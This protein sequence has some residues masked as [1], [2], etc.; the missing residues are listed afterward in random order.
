MKRI[1][2]LTISLLLGLLGA[3]CSSNNSSEIISDLSSIV[4]DKV[5]SVSIKSAGDVVSIYSDET[6][7]FT[8]TV[9]VTGNLSKEVRWSVDD[10]E[11]ATI[12]SNGLLTA[13]KE[14]NVLV[15][16]KS[17]ADTKKFTTFDLTI[18]SLIV[19]THADNTDTLIGDALQFYASNKG[20]PVTENIVWSTSDSTASSI[21]KDGVL[22]SHTWATVTVYAQVGDTKGSFVYTP[23]QK[24]SREMV[25]D[26]LDHTYG[27]VL[28]FFSASS[29]SYGY[30]EEDNAYEIAAYLTTYQKISVV[31]QLAAQFEAFYIYAYD[32]AGAAYAWYGQFSVDAH[33]EYQTLTCLYF[34]DGS[35]FTCY[36]R[37]M[38]AHHTTTYDNDFMSKYLVGTSNDFPA[39]PCAAEDALFVY[40]YSA[41]M[42]FTS[43]TYMPG[44][45]VDV[46][47]ITSQELI[48]YHN[49]MIEAGYSYYAMES[50]YGCWYNEDWSKVVLGYNLIEDY[51]AAEFIYFVDISEAGTTWPKDLLSD[52]LGFEFIAPDTFTGV[53]NFGWA[54]SNACL[55]LT[56][57]GA[58]AGL[59]TYSIKLSDAGWKVAAVYNDEAQ[60]EFLGYFCYPD[61]DV[62]T[63]N[64]YY[65]EVRLFPNGDDIAV[66]IYFS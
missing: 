7:Q 4:E 24:W 22:T 12:D 41:S 53:A 44:V 29:Y 59:E 33:P 2:L 57:Q 5:N 66:N 14:G 15:I 45:L 1:C 42:P 32:S 49:S 37:E 34:Y 43:S 8:A 26:M 38:E 30:V 62:T 56:I 25:D 63:G 48:N 9:D 51:G 6:L 54:S 18:K 35:A 39:I 65:P 64:Y 27:I 10:E 58:G 50:Y 40:E 31:N 20:T 13:K 21:T 23:N 61:Y 47:G 19:I 46:Y 55:C 16:A 11:F 28:P 17:V 36:A 52:S 3:S 60:T